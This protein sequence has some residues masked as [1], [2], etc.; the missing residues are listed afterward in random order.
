MC[1]LTY[2]SLNSAENGR[3]RSDKSS[4]IDGK[5]QQKTEGFKTAYFLR[6]F[7]TV[8]TDEE[9]LNSETFNNEMR[10]KYVTQKMSFRFWPSLHSFQISS[11]NFEESWEI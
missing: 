6:R 10:S 11:V 1:K 9:R 7:H 8:N 5:Y 3:D 4:D 2:I